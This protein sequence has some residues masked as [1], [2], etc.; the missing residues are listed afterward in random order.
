[1][2]II[3]SYHV[4]EYLWRGAHIFHQEN[5][6][7]A[8]H[9]MKDKLTRLL[10]GE[11]EE[12]IADLKEML[13]FLSKKKKGLLQKVITY[14][15]N[16]KEHMRY[17]LYLSK[18]YPIGSGVIEGACKNLVK[19]RMEQCGMHWTIAGAEAML[20]M[21]S[22]QINKMTD[23]YWRYHIAHEKRRLF[24]EFSEENTEELVA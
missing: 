9:W 23:E 4:M 1:V 11:I 14:L 6:P 12:V 22:I 13:K 17:E 24:R 10:Y 8:E 15:K 19:D 3:E 5:T 18:G 21:R 7:E 20:N 16:G 2:I